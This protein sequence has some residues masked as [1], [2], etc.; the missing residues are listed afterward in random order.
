M[1]MTTHYSLL[2][3]PISHLP[4]CSQ[5]NP[6]LLGAPKTS[7]LTIRIAEC[8]RNL[9]GRERKNVGKTSFHRKES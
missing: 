1:R 6:S 3:L 2:N 9:S 7:I 8:A 4:C 5:Y